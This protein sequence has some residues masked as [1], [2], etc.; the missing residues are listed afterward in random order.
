MFGLFL[1][2]IRHAAV[3]R[4]VIAPRHFV[5]DVFLVA[6]EPR[7]QVSQSEFRR[8]IHPGWI[9]SRNVYRDRGDNPATTGQTSC[10][11]RIRVRGLRCHVVCPFW[12]SPEMVSMLLGV[13][14][15]EALHR[16]PIGSEAPV[17]RHLS[18]RGCL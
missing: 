7:L 8:L 9:V 17:L 14:R 6:S 12:H 5:L 15:I 10:F 18:R 2:C 3:N 1:I 13:L 4:D 16:L 11:I